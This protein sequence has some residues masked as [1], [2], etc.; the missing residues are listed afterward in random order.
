MLGK[1]KILIGVASALAVFGGGT[2]VVLA[3]DD[4]KPGDTL[5]AFDKFGESVEKVVTF[6]EEAKAE[7][8]MDILD[9]RMEELKDLEDVSEDTAEDAVE[10]LKEQQERVEERTEEMLN[11]PDNDQAQERERIENRY[12]EQIQEHTQEAAKIQEQLKEQGNNEAAG[13]L[14]KNMQDYQKGKK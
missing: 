2:G 4:A 1:T 9:E 14:E 12:Q 5:Y 3:S 11:A 13:N 6:S 10:E 7:L 8:E